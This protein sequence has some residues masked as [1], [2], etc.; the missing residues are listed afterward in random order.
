MVMIILF[1]CIRWSW[2]K[3][4]RQTLFGE[5]YLYTRGVLL[6]SHSNA[7]IV[8]NNASS[9]LCLEVIGVEFDIPY[10]I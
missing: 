4:S 6:H 7:M 1:Q 5:I 8:S 9:H 3:L 2:S 10:D